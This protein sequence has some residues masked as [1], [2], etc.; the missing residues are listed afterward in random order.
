M[1]SKTP[2]FFKRLF[3]LIFLSVGFILFFVLNGSKYLDLNQIEATYQKVN[4]YVDMHFFKALLMFIVTYILAVFFSIPIKPFLKILGGLLFGLWIAF[5]ASLFSATIGAMLAFMLV[6]HNWGDTSSKE[7]YSVVSKFKGLVQKHPISVLLASRLLPI[8][9]FVPNILAGILKVKNSIF[10][11]TTLI[12]IIPVTF[13]YV[14][15][16]TH[17]AKAIKTSDIK[18]F[19]D[20]KFIL[21]ISILAILALIPL[22]FN[23]LKLDNKK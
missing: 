14:W 19:I 8:P 22:F 7:N 13:I 20:W 4:Y 16:G 11:F 10:F 17:V 21:A 12:G 9:F 18:D 1:K 3:L 15:L 5:F 2:L 6:K 23:K